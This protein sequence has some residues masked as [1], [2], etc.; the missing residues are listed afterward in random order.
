MKDDGGAD[1]TGD[2][3]RDETSLKCAASF[4]KTQLRGPVAL[5]ASDT[6]K[7]VLI[8]DA[9]ETLRLCR[10]PGSDDDAASFS[11]MKPPPNAAGPDGF[12]A[13]FGADVL[14]V[15]V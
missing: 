9:G 14:N 6:P 11:L 3:E 2:A 10:I 8:F 13:R 15:N 1:G 5:E 12:V 4:G 7:A